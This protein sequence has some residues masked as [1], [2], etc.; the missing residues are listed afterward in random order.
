VSTPDGRWIVYTDIS[1]EQPTV[2]RVPIGGGRPERLTDVSRR[3]PSVS[4][5]GRMVA[6]FRSAG[7]RTG[8]DRES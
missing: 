4:P 1:S 6:C 5:D 3:N 2:W 7:G 8:S